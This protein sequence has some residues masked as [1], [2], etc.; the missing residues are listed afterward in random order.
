MAAYM[1][2]LLEGARGDRTAL[3]LS[4]ARFAELTH[5]AAGNHPSVMGVGSIFLTLNWNGV[6]GFGHGGDWPGFHS[7]I[8]LLPQQNAGVFISLMAEWP[9]ASPFD[10]KPESAG[11][12]AQP[13]AEVLT[14]LSNGGALIS[15]M[16]HVFGPDTPYPGEALDI[17]VRELAGAY[18]HEYRAYGTLAELLD[19]LGADSSVI[20]VTAHDEGLMINGKG[21]YRPVGGNV[22]WNSEL[23]T[24]PDGL[25]TSTPIWVFARDAQ[26]GEIYAAPRLA[27]DPFVKVGLFDN[28]AT[29]ARMLPFLLL[30][31]VSGVVAVFWRAKRLALGHGAR[32]AAIL[33]SLLAVGGVL[34][35]LM[36]FNGE[37]VL[38]DYLMGEPARF[39]ALS[40]CLN[41][42]A[43]CMI[44]LLVAFALNLRRALAT[45]SFPALEMAHLALLCATGVVALVF[46]ADF[47]LLGWQAP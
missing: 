45:K 18:R 40:F 11:A 39:I 17:P 28:P 34:A 27:I 38:G 43:L 30:A 5:R 32:W 31:F 10:A 46:F 42:M 22:F 41:G 29:Y 20:E 12:E 4:P 15:F 21:P 47:H 14:P 35:L 1:I 25:F 16:A 23:E 36:R 26:T 2:A 13:E 8:W 24:A 37:T 9:D 44:V 7:I 19:V 3:N 33:S 6:E